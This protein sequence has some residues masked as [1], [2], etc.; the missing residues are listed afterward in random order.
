MLSKRPK[1]SSVSTTRH[2][3]ATTAP[4]FILGG[5]PIFPAPV[6]LVR[7]EATLDDLRGFTRTVEVPL[8]GHAP[9]ASAGLIFAALEPSL[10]EVRF[11]TQSGILTVERSADGRHGM[12]LPAGKVE[13]LPAPPRV[14]LA[15]GAALRVGPPS[16]IHFAPTC[17]RRT[18]APPGIPQEA[19]VRAMRD[20]R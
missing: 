12:A 9:L 6:C 2:G 11:A 15:L 5:L 16:E 13:S 4:E 18:P 8:C 20:L 19:V 10:L 1:P 7:G 3:T 17:A 14:C